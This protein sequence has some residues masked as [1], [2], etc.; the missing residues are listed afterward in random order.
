MTLMAAN[1]ADPLAALKRA[2]EIRLARAQLK[3]QLGSG[4][5][6]AATV[7]RDCPE[8]ARTWAVL[9]LLASQPQWGHSKSTRLLRRVGIG[10]RMP[11]GQLTQRQRRVLAT[12]LQPRGSQDHGL[13]DCGGATT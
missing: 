6:L 4:T 8:E 7:I 2:N 3:R 11:L 10:E 5:L 9:Q 1:T 12:A 13:L